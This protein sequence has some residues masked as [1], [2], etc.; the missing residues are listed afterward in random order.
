MSA[1]FRRTKAQSRSHAWLDL[2]QTSGPFLT[3]PVLKRVFGDTVPGLPTST[4]AR[5][6]TSAENVLSSDGDTRREFID[7]M[8]DEVFDWGDRCA[9]SIPESL[10]APIPE[11]G[12]IVRPDFGFQM[13]SNADTD[14]EWR[15]F[16]IVVPWG[17]H[18]LTRSANGSWTAS[19]AEQLAVLLRARDVPIGI[20]TDGRWWAIVWAPRGEAMGV[21]VWDAS[22]FSEEPES[23]AALVALMNRSRFLGVA[24]A[25]RLPELLQE[26]SERQEDITDQLGVQVRDAVELLIGTLDRLDAESDG[27][28]LDGVDDDELYSGAVTM[29]MRIIFI[30]FAEE[31]RLLPSDLEIYDEGY[32]IGSLKADLSNHALLYG[33]QT[34]EHRTGAWHRLL[35]TSRALY[36]GVA[37][38]DLRLPAYGG[39]LFDPDEHPWLEGRSKNASGADARPP[40]IDDRTVRKILRAVQYVELGTGK[41]RELRRL[42][43]RTL[44]VEQIGYV[45]EG[46]L[47]LEVRTAEEVVVHLERPRT[48]PNA[49]KSCEIGLSEV[50]PK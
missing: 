6:R 26:S 16:G 44:G 48:W 22:L 20:A 45:Y 5:T 3:L 15:L 19:A 40:A 37:H 25:D 32:S 49:Q 34:L 1:A 30:L 14:N 46:L 39:T 28:M 12:Q 29:M 8:L 35:A 31:R 17:T 7:L 24:D 42:T 18:P 27:K 47:E 23:A 36:S 41:N 33:K 10:S 13:A 50:W 2:L 43:F 38:E 21:A 4:R 11:H 9:A